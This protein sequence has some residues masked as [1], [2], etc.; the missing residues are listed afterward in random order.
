M[1]EQAQARLL[2]LGGVRAGDVR[3]R[4]GD[5]VIHH[6]EA[7]RGR[8]LVLLHGAGGGGA[9]WYRLLGSLGAERRVLAPD[10]PGFAFTDPVTLDAPLGAAAAAHL[11][12][13]LDQVGIEACDVA[14]TSFGGLIGL[15]LAQRQR[16]RVDRL[17]L[18]DSVGLGVE[19]PW[20]VRLACTRPGG[21][22]LMRRTSRAGIRAQLRLLMTSERLPSEHEAAL[23]AYLHASSLQDRERRLP[24][25]LRQFG[26][27]R[28][29]V[30]ILSD[31]ELRVL[32]LPVLLVWG[33]HDRF[34]PRSH[35][36]RA[37]R[38]LP[39]S[40]LEIIADSGHSPNWEQPAAV[41]DVMRAFL[42]P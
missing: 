2:A 40:R 26:G 12:A 6:L 23:V 19:L 22:V 25:A 35:A 31:E 28:G 38:L 24:R 4:V 17:V 27:V 37:H 15:R 18:L 29:Q 10:L 9:N 30:E 20:L 13:W 41:L 39:D 1:L 36:E 5:V 7:G 42:P 8:P 14:G 11:E 34:T 3:T 16:L 32:A 33:E 21:A